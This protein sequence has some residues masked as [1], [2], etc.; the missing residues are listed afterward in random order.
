MEGI[1]EVT[2]RVILQIVPFGVEAEAREIGRIDISN[3]M[4]QKGENDTYA[5][6]RD[7]VRSGE[8]VQHKRDDGA[9]ELVRKVLNL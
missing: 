1:D 6:I 3:Q 4:I 5:Y 9:W 2:L 7:G 8:L